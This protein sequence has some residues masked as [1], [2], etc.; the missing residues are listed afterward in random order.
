M[1]E[2]EMSARIEAIR[3]KDEREARERELRRLSLESPASSPVNRTWSFVWFGGA[4]LFLL[5][6]VLAVIWGP[7]MFGAGFLA[8][9]GVAFLVRGLSVR[10]TL[11]EHR[12]RDDS[13]TIP[14]SSPADQLR[15][16]LPESGGE[17]SMPPES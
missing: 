11:Q 4:F 16:P 2:S 17:P 10:R 8:A 13:R 14:D 12:A 5:N 6:A 7:G 3:A 9:M 1:N 15:A